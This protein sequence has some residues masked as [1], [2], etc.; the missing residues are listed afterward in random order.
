MATTKRSKEEQELWTQFA[1]AAVQNYATPEDIEDVDEQVNDMA[2][3]AATFAD[4]MLDEWSE[5]FAG[6]PRRGRKSKRSKR[7]VEEEPEETEEPEEDPDDD[8]DLD[9]DDDE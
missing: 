1:V 4:A 2:D 3:L 5:R 8:D 9:E 7:K 6:G